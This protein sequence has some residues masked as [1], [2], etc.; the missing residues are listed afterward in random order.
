MIMR[1][2]ELEPDPNS[3]PAKELLNFFMA[4]SSVPVRLKKRIPPAGN[5]R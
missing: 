3:P 5:V 4:P 2:F 1:N